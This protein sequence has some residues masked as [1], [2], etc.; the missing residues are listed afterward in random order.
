MKRKFVLFTLAIVLFLSGCNL[1][2]TATPTAAMDEN[3]VITAAAATAFTKLTEIAGLTT[4]TPSPTYTSTPEPPT[5]TPTPTVEVILVPM[6]AICIDNSRVRSWPGSGGEFLGGIFYGRG[7]KVLARNDNGNWLLIEF[8][9]APTGRGWIL[10]GGVELKGEVAQLPIALERPD[11]QLVFVPPVTWTVVGTPLPLPTFVVVDSSRPATVTQMAIVRVCPT[12]SCQAIGYLQV[13]DK[14]NMTG[15]FGENKWA[16]FEYPSG[17][18]GRGWVSR[19]NIQP[20]EAAFGGLPYFDLLGNLVTPEP[21]TSTP[22]PNIS[23]TPTRTATAVPAGPLVEIVD[24]TTVYSLMSSLSPVAGTL[25]PKDRVRITALSINR[26]WYEIEYPF[27][28][29]G[30]AYISA[31]EKYVRLLPGQDY[32]YMRYT[33]ALGTPLAPP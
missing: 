20:S 1:P 4:A 15:R 7:V 8:P 10:Q 32:R 17:P 28:T 21:P 30:R 23:P 5:V 24:V 25:N 6:D 22:D 12:K 31:S 26:L 14:I 19:D 13:G 33:D 3:A 27:D 2:E 16:Q 18:G 29:D 9:E 11:S